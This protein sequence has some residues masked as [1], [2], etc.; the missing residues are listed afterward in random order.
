MRDQLKKAIKLAK[1]TGDKI[2]VFDSPESEDAYIIMPF[3]DYEKMVEIETNSRG[4]TEIEL[5]DK[6]NRDI[7]IWKSEQDLNEE[8][9]LPTTH[10]TVFPK[11]ISEV[12]KEKQKKSGW[13]IPSQRKE[14][15]AEIEE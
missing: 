12:I 6:I 15:A 7:A 13:N 10:N 1:K 3:E 11:H 2:M 14:K 9:A 5:I 4:L 8:Y